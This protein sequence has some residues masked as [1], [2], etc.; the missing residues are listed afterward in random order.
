MRDLLSLLEDG[1]ANCT[2]LKK[3][4]DK[5]FISPISAGPSL[6]C[7]KK[8]WSK[9]ALPLK[10]WDKVVI[11]PKSVGQ[12]L[13]GTMSALLFKCNGLKLFYLIEVS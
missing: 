8:C 11:A 2:L 3:V 13:H 6:H 4:R 9:S 7:S 1:A 12:C 5:V 10:V